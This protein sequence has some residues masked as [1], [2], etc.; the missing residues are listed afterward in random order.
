MEVPNPAAGTDA[1]SVGPTASAAMIATAPIEVATAATPPARAVTA[2]GDAAALGASRVRVSARM[3][4]STDAASTT[5]ATMS[6]PAGTA[7]VGMSQTATRAMLAR[8]GIRAVMT[9]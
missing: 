3:S 7:M 1:C 5:N 2:R 4:S 6:T 8:S 9:T